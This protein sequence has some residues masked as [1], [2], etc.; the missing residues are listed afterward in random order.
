MET[1]GPVYAGHHVLTALVTVGVGLG[2]VLWRRA[3]T[4]AAPAARNGHRVLAVVLPMMLLWVAVADHVVL[5]ATA[6]L[7][8]LA[9]TSTRWLEQGSPIPVIFRLW[10]LLG[11]SGHGRTG[12]L[13]LLLLVAMLCDAVRARRRDYWSVVPSA[14]PVWADRSATWWQA[15]VGRSAAPGLHQQIRAAVAAA[16][17]AVVSLAYVVQRDLRLTLTLHARRSDESRR[18]AMLRGRVGLAMQREA[19]EIAA[20][21]DAGAGGRHRWRLVALLVVVLLLVVGLVAG[22]ALARSIGWDTTFSGRWLAGLAEDLGKWWNTLSPGQQLALTALAALALALPFGFGWGLFLAGGIT[23][24]AAHGQGAGALLRNPRQATRDYLT[25]RSLGGMAIDAGE[26]A[27][28]FIPAGLGAAGGVAAKGALRSGIDDYLADREAWRLARR[29]HWSQ[30]PERGAIS[31]GHADGLPRV[32]GKKPRGFEF[33]DTVY[34]GQATAASK[35]WPAAVQAAYPNGIRYTTS[36]FPDFSPYATHTVKL[37][38]FSG[39]RRLDDAAANQLANLPQKTPDYTWHHHEDLTTMLLVPSDL[40]R[41]VS[42]T[43]GHAIAKS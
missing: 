14:G 40:H 30:H 21:L 43:G 33:A 5:N 3:S 23:Y 28:T 6:Q 12:L 7:G 1:D 31:W 42:H 13:V 24:L 38:G 37:P 17:V 36:G 39:V 18:E 15:R 2:I 29:T 20:D 11:G 27:L 4:R 41:A 19:R 25:D 22:P 9:G 35:G 16:G 26:F 8:G 10:G 32:N 34:K